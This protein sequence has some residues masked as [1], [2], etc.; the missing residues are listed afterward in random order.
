LNIIDKFLSVDRRYIFIVVA[1]GVIIP[2]LAPLKLGVTESPPVKR[3]YDF[4]EDYPEGS[5][6]AVLVSFDYDPSTQ[7]ELSP[8]AE[9]ILIQCFE[10]KIPVVAICLH[11]GGPGLALEALSVTAD[12]A[13]AVYGEDYVFLGYKV[14][15]SAVILSMGENIKTVFPIDYWGTSV[16]ELPLMG[17]VANYNDIHLA[18]TL[19]GTTYPDVWVAFAHERYDANVA[20]GVTAV[21]AAD[22][23]PYLQTG[24]MVGL[25]GGLKGAAEYEK[26]IGYE[27]IFGKPGKGIKG[28]DAQTVIH[29]FIVLIVILGNIA[30]MMTLRSKRRELLDA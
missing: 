6:K 7:P 30:Y 25:I 20:A 5:D 24:Q 11:P 22:Y 2:F 15:G 23:Y 28:M 18:I 13:G 9:A 1:I 26:L 19:S 27:D 8:M 14:G 21:M 12:R 29:V 3:V 16:E 10:K 4:I 17:K